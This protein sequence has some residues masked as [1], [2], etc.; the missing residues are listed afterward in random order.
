MTRTMAEAFDEW[1]RLFIEEPETF[2]HEFQE[3]E[4]YR[5]GTYGE[6][7]AAL[8]TKLMGGGK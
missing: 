1:M 8:L 4:M 2:L 5:A 3:V 7:S 6:A